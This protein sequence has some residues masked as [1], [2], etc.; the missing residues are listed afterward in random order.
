M[1]S[2]ATGRV[3]DTSAELAILRQH[4]STTVPTVLKDLSLISIV[5]KWSGAETAAPLA[6]FFV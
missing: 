1:A 5:P 6:V 2:Q 3:A 4:V